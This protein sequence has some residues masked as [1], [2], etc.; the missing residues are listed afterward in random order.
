MQSWRCAFGKHSCNERQSEENTV[1]FHSAYSN[2]SCYQCMESFHKKV[3]YPYTDCQRFPTRLHLRRCGFSDRYC[4]VERVEW[5]GY[6]VTM[7]RGC[8]DLCYWG[9]R[10]EGFGITRLR[11]TSCCNQA[12]GCNTDNGVLGSTP[13]DRGRFIPC[14][15]A[16]MAVLLW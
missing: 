12:N 9:C 8:T 6:V 13:Q 11:C 3:W 7:E 2:L 16:L 5:N 4:K 1:S 14:V 10:Y 15:A